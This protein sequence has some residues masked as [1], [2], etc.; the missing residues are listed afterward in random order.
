MKVVIGGRLRQDSVRNGLEAIEK[1]CDI[2]VIHDGARPFIAPAFIEKG[3]FLMEMFDAVIMASPAWAAGALL[4]GV[5]PVL[6]KELSAIPY[7]S[8]ITINLI[9]DE[10]QLGRL[11]DGFGFLIPVVEGYGKKTL[12]I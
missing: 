10:D 8:S 11:P 5:D 12:W 2:V 3:I 6:G 4:G 7:S 1:P 9:Y